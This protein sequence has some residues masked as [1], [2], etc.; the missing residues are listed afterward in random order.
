MS[1][2]DL[3]EL[4]VSQ[5]HYLVT[6]DTDQKAKQVAV[7]SV[8][9]QRVITPLMLPGD[10][11]ALLDAVFDSGIPAGTTLKFLPGTYTLRTGVL[12]IPNDRVTLDFTGSIINVSLP[13][14]ANWVQSNGVI[15]DGNSKQGFTIR[16]GKWVCAGDPN[17]GGNFGKC[18]YK[19]RI[20]SAH[21]CSDLKLIDMECVGCT[22][23][24]F[25]FGNNI[26]VFNPKGTNTET[27]INYQQGGFESF[28]LFPYTT[29]FWVINP[30][31]DG[32]GH[33]VHW[34][35]G[36]N[37]ASGAG[38]TN[39]YAD[40]T[41]SRPVGPGRIV[42]GFIK[43]GSGGGAWGS[44]GNDIVASFC[45]I[46]NWG[47]TC[48]DDEGGIN[49]RA[50]H[51]T[52]RDAFNAGVIATFGH[53]KGHKII[54]CTIEITQA[55]AKFGAFFGSPIM[56]DN[57]AEDITIQ[58]NTFDC[59]I[60]GQVGV[61]RPDGT[62]FKSVNIIGNT[63]KNARWYWHEVGS[64]KQIIRDNTVEYT[65]A[66]DG[67][68][69]GTVVGTATE[70]PL[71]IVRNNTI[72]T[73]AGGN[74]GLS[75]FNSDGAYCNAEY[76]EGNRIIGFTN[77][78]DLKATAANATA[79]LKRYVRGNTFG[80]G[81]VIVGQPTAGLRQQVIVSNNHLD[82]GTVW[83][84]LPGANFALGESTFA[85]N[86]LF[87]SSVITDNYANANFY[88]SPYS[89]SESTNEFV[90]VYLKYRQTIGEV[91]I[92]PRGD[93]NVGDGWPV[94]YVI[95][96]STNGGSTWQTVATRTNQVKPSSVSYRER[97]TFPAV[98]ADAVRL[99]STKLWQDPGNSAYI[100]QIKQLEVYAPGRPADPTLPTVANL[101]AAQ[102]L[103]VQLPTLILVSTDVDYNDTNALY[104][105][106]P[107]SLERLSKT[108]L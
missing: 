74:V 22:L 27:G 6:T 62:A 39:G 83:P 1:F 30:E 25:P 108:T 69:C 104:L 94:S 76:I 106:T 43:N 35:G 15:F 87:S 105:K 85:A 98:Q 11:T 49:C 68:T 82:D 20:L 63:F 54:N 14:G 90:G 91:V 99:R 101:T 57:T 65:V 89:F 9:G 5:P 17:E 66:E 33:G 60:A 81:N 95:E 46:E 40:L 71:L 3:D 59:K 24:R 12:S 52:L 96:V 58:D 34:D 42:G 38:Y 29:N 67:P 47:D 100:L 36:T 2:L 78:L 102:A 31:I 61:I 73:T 97:I 44:R 79:S 32:F 93:A 103:T 45:T 7:E 72:T 56:A 70:K 21:G 55:G 10:M 16:G 23:G 84:K 37:E 50:V 4:L 77:D 26:K 107:T 51:C 80:A 88:S 64:R 8:V 18:A 86:T 75:I 13:A 92:A 28:L 48:W 53:V 19:V 41:A